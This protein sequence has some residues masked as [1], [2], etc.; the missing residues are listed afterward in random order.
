[1]L[2]RR[3]GCRFIIE[4]LVY[5][6]TLAAFLG[7]SSLL[8]QKGRVLLPLDLTTGY[9]YNSP[10]DV[11]PFRGSIDATGAIRIGKRLRAGPS[12]GFVI[13]DSTKAWVIG[14]QLSYSLFA[15]KDFE[16]LVNIDVFCR[17]SW[18]P[19]TTKMV[20][21]SAGVAATFLGV[22]TG[23]IVTRD[24]HRQRSALGLIFGLEPVTF[25]KVVKELIGGRKVLEL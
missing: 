18:S 10:G 6:V 9:I 13:A 23:V 5:S 11:V 19:G 3:K 16:D 20:P 14:G 17:V 4:H 15:V 7:P 8:G 1:M 25:I 2:S 12:L 22:R 21:L 24:T